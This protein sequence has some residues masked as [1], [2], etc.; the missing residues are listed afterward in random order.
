MTELTLLVYIVLLT[1]FGVIAGL[2]VGYIIFCLKTNQFNTGAKIFASTIAIT[3]WLVYITGE[4]IM[5]GLT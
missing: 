4:A 2:K 1:L 3:L 5:K